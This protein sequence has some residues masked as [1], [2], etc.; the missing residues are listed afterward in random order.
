MSLAFVMQ[1][2]I[3]LLCTSAMHLLMCYAATQALWAASNRTLGTMGPLLK[4]QIGRPSLPD[5][6]NLFVTMSIMTKPT[7]TGKHAALSVHTILQK[8]LHCTILV[9]LIEV[10]SWMPKASKSYTSANEM[11]I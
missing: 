9:W 5:L 2:G 7:E 3:V 11:I 4:I 6:S 10:V 8:L 1:S